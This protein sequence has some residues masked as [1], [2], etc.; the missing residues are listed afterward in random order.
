VQ[1]DDAFV[2]WDNITIS[3]STE[4][5]EREN[6]SPEW[7]RCIVC[8]ARWEVDNAKKTSVE[9]SSTPHVVLAVCQQTMAPP[10]NNSAS[11]SPMP[12][13]HVARASGMLMSIWARNAGIEVLDVSPAIPGAGKTEEDKHKETE[14]KKARRMSD[15]YGRGRGRGRG[16]IGA[17]G[18]SP[19]GGRGIKG[20]GFGGGVKTGKPGKGLVERPA[21]V[22]A[23]MEPGRPIVRVLARGEK[24]DAPP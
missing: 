15:G 3:Q 19:G 2:P 20:G 8:C 4:D 5:G 1:R 22:I 12:T 14:D 21:T 13:Y 24:L 18:T 23:M 7:A 9:A 11:G 10:G 6:I 16:A 17:T